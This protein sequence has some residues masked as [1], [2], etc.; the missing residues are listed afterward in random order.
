MVMEHLEDLENYV[1]ETM[2]VIPTDDDDFLNEFEGVVIG[3]RNGFLQVKDA[4]D[5]VWEVAK[6]Q[7]TV[8]F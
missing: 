4:D 8:L 2:L 6:S 7:V 5:D 1:G 3:I